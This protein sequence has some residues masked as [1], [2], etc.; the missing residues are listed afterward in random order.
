MRGK[1]VQGS[2]WKAFP[3]SLNCGG[4]HLNRILRFTFRGKGTQCVHIFQVEPGAI[5]AAEEDPARFRVRLAVLCRFD[6]NTNPVAMD[7]KMVRLELNLLGIRF[8]QLRRRMEIFAQRLHDGH[9]LGRSHRRRVSLASRRSSR[10]RLLGGRWVRGKRAGA[11]R[12]FCGS[13][14]SKLTDRKFAIQLVDLSVN[15]SFFDPGDA[16]R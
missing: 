10:R 6:V 1:D 7:L 11:F 14:A 2:I 9:A 13:D 12:S 3:N 16:G 5:T 8:C 15:D 4:A